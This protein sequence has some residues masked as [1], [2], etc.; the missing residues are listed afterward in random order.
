MRKPVGDVVGPAQLALQGD[1]TV[2][3]VGGVKDGVDVEGI[4][5]EDDLSVCPALVKCLVD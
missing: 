1:I 4:V 2:D 5:A 3:Q